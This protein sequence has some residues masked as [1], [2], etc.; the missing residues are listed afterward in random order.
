[1]D[2]VVK[3]NVRMI[4]ERLMKTGPVL[5]EA[6]KKG[7]LEITAAYYDLKSGGVELL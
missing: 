4:A 1:V 2:E 6:V 3:V 7:H 5:A